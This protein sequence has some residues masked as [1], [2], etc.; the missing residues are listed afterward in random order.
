MKFIYLLLSKYT[1]KILLYSRGY[2][3][4]VIKQKKYLT[5]SNQYGYDGLT[6]HVDVHLSTAET[7]N[8]GSSVTNHDKIEIKTA[9]V[10]YFK[11]YIV[12]FC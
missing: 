3:T 9:I 5:L 10:I 12:R 6:Y 7:W 1:Q 11:K 2:R 4:F 8:D